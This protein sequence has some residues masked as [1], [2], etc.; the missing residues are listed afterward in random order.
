MQATLLLLCLALGQA[1]APTQSAPQAPQAVPTKA[2]A[3]QAERDKLQAAWKANDAPMAEDY[4][5]M[6]EAPQAARDKGQP[7]GEGAGGV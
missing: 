4:Q 2:E 6:P 7:G 1:T 5:V 3:A